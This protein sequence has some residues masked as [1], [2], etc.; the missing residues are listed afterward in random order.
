MQISHRKHQKLHVCL[1][2][3][4]HSRQT[5]TITQRPYLS[6]VHSRG[7]G[8]EYRKMH[9]HTLTYY[10][11]MY[12]NNSHASVDILKSFLHANRWICR[13]KQT[14]VASL[15][16]RQQQ[17]QILKHHVRLAEIMIIMRGRTSYRTESRRANVNDGGNVR[18][19]DFDTQ[20]KISKLLCY[21][22]IMW[23]YVK[24]QTGIK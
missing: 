7:N 2:F 24:A 21:K 3:C 16:K 5:H 8:E 22:K 11:H 15:P 1:H 12:V 4:S 10:M 9:E 18:S 14:D 17:R 20:P 19:I 13:R 6:M 23:S